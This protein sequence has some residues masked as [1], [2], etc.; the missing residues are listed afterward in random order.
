MDIIEAITLAG[1]RQADL[2]RVFCEAG[3]GISKQ[4]V[5]L[6]VTNDR[7]PDAWRWRLAGIKPKWFRRSKVAKVKNFPKPKKSTEA[8]V[9]GASKKR[10]KGSKMA[11]K[12]PP[13]RPKV[14][15]DP[16]TQL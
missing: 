9:P 4:A 7:M 5:S 1:G 8:G 6:W 10:S 11:P 13:F 12:G 16:E 15:G 2:V 3:Y 14:Y